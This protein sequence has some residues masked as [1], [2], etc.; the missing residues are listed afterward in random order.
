M[1][2]WFE[3]FDGQIV[4]DDDYVWILREDIPADLTHGTVLP[5]LRAHRGA[6]IGTEL[7]PATANGLGT[8]RIKV[9]SGRTAPRDRHPAG[10]D[11]VRFSLTSNDRFSTVHLLLAAT[12]ADAMEAVAPDDQ[13]R[14]ALD[15][16]DGI[17]TQAELAGVLGESPDVMQVVDGVTWNSVGKLW[18]AAGGTSTVPA[19]TRLEWIRALRELTRR[20][21]AN[22]GIKTLQTAVGATAL[23]HLDSQR[24]GALWESV[25]PEVLPPR[26]ETSSKDAGDE[27]VPGKPVQARRSPTAEPQVRPRTRVW[28]KWDSATSH[29]QETR[30]GL[31][32]PANS[33]DAAAKSPEGSGGTRGDKALRDRKTAFSGRRIRV[34]LDCDG[35]RVKAIFDP[36]TGATEITSAPVRALLGSVHADPDA[37]AGAVTTTFRLGDE[38]PFDGWQLWRI[39]DNSG[40]PLAEVPEARP[41]V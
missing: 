6:V 8:L 36:E 27:V 39:D 10:F 2:Q 9:S 21:P 12:A 41:V 11:T 29:D 4:L 22:A 18:V 24:I 5:T 23:R 1:A 30:A 38:G 28:T 13:L 35:H 33:T 20:V 16:L 32:R 3:G 31:A 14:A 34:H 7:R 19:D 25:L 17:A 37:A 26:V 15:E 40:R